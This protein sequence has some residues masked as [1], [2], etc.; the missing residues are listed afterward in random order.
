ML[1]TIC[2]AGMA[3]ILLVLAYAIWHYQL[4]T[5]LDTAET[6][7]RYRTSDFA[8]DVEAWLRHEGY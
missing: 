6:M 1:V 5:V 4:E 2:L 3:V 8:G 7:E